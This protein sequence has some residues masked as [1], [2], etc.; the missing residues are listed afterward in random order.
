MQTIDAQIKTGE[1]SRF[2]LIYGEEPYMVRYYKNKCKS[3]LS[4]EGDDMNASFFE[5]NS[6]SLEEVNSLGNTLPFFAEKRLLLMENTEL[7]KASNDVVDMLE[8]F[9]DTT[10]VVFVEKQVDK[11]NRLYKWMQKNGC[12]TECVLQQEKDLVP[13]AARYLKG[14]GK[15]ISRS[16]M[17][18]IVSKVGFQMDML[19]NELDK[20]IGYTGER[21]EITVADVDEICSGQV[22]GKIFDMI[23]AVIAGQTEKVFRLYGDLIELKEPPLVILHLLGRHINILLQVKEI[24]NSM[25]DRDLAKKVGIPYFTV[26]K[27][28]SQA[29][30]FSKKQLL[31]LLEER[32][33]YEERFK[34]GRL[35]ERLVAEF[36]LVKALTNE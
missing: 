30:H 4:N 13:W 26:G 23:D 14:Y 19:V 10:Y 29:K 3:M 35:G 8:E 15:N 12:V 18:Y 9:P 28:K 2:H 5:G 25:A 24:G 6:I 27:Y 7:F 20:L 22:V 1:L 32:A 36:F 21:E 34:T 16:T 17:E 31:H 33:D 11:R